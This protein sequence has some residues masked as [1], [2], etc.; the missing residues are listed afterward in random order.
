MLI[1]NNFFKGLKAVVATKATANLKGIAFI[2]KVF[3]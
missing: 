3:F 2:N 1:I